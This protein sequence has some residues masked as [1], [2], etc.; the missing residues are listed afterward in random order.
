MNSGY[1]ILFFS[2]KMTL[3]VFYFIDRFN[4]LPDFQT[5]DMTKADS[6]SDLLNLG[7]S[8]RD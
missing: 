1:E 7:G 2:F 8:G 4:G 3:T 5:F 6:T